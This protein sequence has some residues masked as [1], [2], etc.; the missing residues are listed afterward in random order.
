MGSQ[1]QERKETTRL[2]LSDVAIIA[3]TVAAVLAV[4]AG[5]AIAYHHF[6]A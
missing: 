4:A 3:W 1:V 6:I 2:R 5:I